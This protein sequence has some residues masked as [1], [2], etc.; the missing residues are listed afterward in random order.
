MFRNG[1]STN[2]EWTWRRT[3][4]EQFDDLERR[5]RS[6]MALNENLIELTAQHQIACKHC[7]SIADIALS[8]SPVSMMC[9]TCRQTLGSWETTPQ[10]IA[11]IT[12]FISQR[13]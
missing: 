13:K 1:Y 5:E 8:Q 12:A 4:E 10:S 9:P 6:V 7:H 3:S 11:E 2:G